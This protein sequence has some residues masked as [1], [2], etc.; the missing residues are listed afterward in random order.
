MSDYIDYLSMQENNDDTAPLSSDENDMANKKKFEVP[1]VA[2]QE[3]AYVIDS[4]KFPNI[5]YKPPP[6]GPLDWQILIPELPTI[7]LVDKPL[8]VSTASALNQPTISEQKT[9]NN[10]KLIVY[11]YD[12]SSDN[13]TNNVYETTSSTYRQL[14]NGGP[15]IP[16]T[17]R[18]SF[19][20]ESSI[21]GASV[22]DRSQTAPT[23]DTRPSF[24][25]TTRKESLPHQRVYSYP[26]YSRGHEPESF[27][28]AFNSSD[29][30][31][32][33][34]KS[35]P[36]TTKQPTA[37]RKRFHNDAKGKD[38]GKDGDTWIDIT[39]RLIA[40]GA[41]AD[42]EHQDLV[43]ATL[44]YKAVVDKRLTDLTSAVSGLDSAMQQLASYTPFANIIR[45]VESIMEDHND[46]PDGVQEVTKELHDTLDK[47]AFSQTINPFESA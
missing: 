26:A 39:K 22:Q 40:D 25:N 5:L 45:T 30:H 29:T 43:D 17:A 47:I 46:D 10:Q 42:K 15:P 16:I 31:C 19:M 27:P 11:R 28:V 34:P 8:K 18:D 1:T 14:F 21:Q 36:T 12:A 3:K 6:E 7:H 41:R 20:V 13:N 23:Q 38:S 2:Q 9:V 37:Q 4:D 35:T 33:Q 44:A 24:E 32:R